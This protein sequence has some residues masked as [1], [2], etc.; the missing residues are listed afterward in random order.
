MQ[1]MLFLSLHDYFIIKCCMFPL[2][3]ISVDKH[4][5]ETLYDVFKCLCAKQRKPRLDR[6]CFREILHNK[7]DLTEDIIMDR[8]M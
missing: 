2:P 1:M 6:L 7:F 3:F 5:I 4:E 8:S